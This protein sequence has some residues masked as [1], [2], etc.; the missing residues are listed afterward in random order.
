MS[1]G[2]AVTTYARQTR[3]FFLRISLFWFGLSF[4]WGGMNIQILPWRIDRFVRDG[5]VPEEIKGT[6]LGALVF[7]GL[8]VA[9]VVQPVAGAISDRATLRW[10]RR[11]PFM[12][13]GVA[14]SIP[15]LIFVGV[16]P[17]YGWLFV[18]LVLLQIGANIAHGPYQ[19]VIPDQVAPAKRGQASGFLGLANFVG[20]LAGA[21]VAGAWLSEGHLLP[22]M[23]TIVAVLSLSSLVTWRVVKESRAPAMPPFGGVMR[24]FSQRLRELGARPAFVWLMLS[25]LFFFMGLQAMDNFLQFFFRDGLIEPDLEIDIFGF[26]FDLGPE[27]K[28]TGVLAVVLVLAVLTA[29]PG[30]WVADRY[31]KLR[32]VAV[33]ASLGVLSA[34]LMMTAQS[35]VQVLGYAVFLGIGVGLFTAADWAVAIDLIPDPR[36]PGLYMGLS[37]VATAGGDALATVSAGIALDL[38]GFRGVFAMMGIFFGITLLVLI[39]VR[40]AL[41]RTDVSVTA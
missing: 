21:G 25:R 37:N 35:F 28:T 16:A 22:A 39:G 26:V 31:G 20:T 4:I 34:A 32:V 19:G 1:V 5:L 40:E 14:A 2:Q 10:G 3:W 38:V 17:N 18:A 33:A 6:A 8:V 9:I 7:V 36:A 27:F 41:A 12:A 29:V 30:G 24:E 11:R 15:F 23:L 13:A